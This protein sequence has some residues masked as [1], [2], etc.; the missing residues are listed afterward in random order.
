MKGKKDS[1][2]VMVFMTA[3]NAEAAAIIGERAVIEGL[4]AC[5]NIVPLVKSIY[6]WKGRLCKEDEALAIFKTRQGLFERLKRRIKELH[7]YEVPEIICVDI[8]AGLK[9]YLDWITENTDNKTL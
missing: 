5:C 7:G 3:S 9:E 8:N 1:D 2:H 6:T 4:A